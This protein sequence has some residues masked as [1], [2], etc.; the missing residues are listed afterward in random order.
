MNVNNFTLSKG[1]TPRFMSKVGA[2]FSIVEQ[3]VKDMFKL[4]VPPDI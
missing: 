3:M 1:L 2:S 4:E